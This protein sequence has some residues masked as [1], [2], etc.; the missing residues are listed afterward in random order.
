ME[1]NILLLILCNF[2]HKSHL[3]PVIM[4]KLCHFISNL[5]KFIIADF[6]HFIQVFLRNKMFDIILT[7]KSADQLP[8]LQV[9]GYYSHF[10]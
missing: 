6:L 7:S 5:V 9:I 4:N 2:I 8:Q 1:I 10:A 3:N